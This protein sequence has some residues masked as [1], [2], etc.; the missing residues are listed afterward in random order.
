MS[1]NE[2][3]KHF[4]ALNKS[5]QESSDFPLRLSWVAEWFNAR[6]SK[7]GIQAIVSAV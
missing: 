1:Y 3:G 7:C 5:A 6:R 2:F 4:C